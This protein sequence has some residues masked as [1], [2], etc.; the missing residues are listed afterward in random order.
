MSSGDLQ[1]HIEQNDYFGTLATVL[2]LL[3]QDLHR[4]GYHRHAEKLARLRDELQHLQR[5]YRIERRQVLTP[6]RR[7]PRSR[8]TFLASRHAELET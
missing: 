7:K 1:F 5:H 6:P 4:K 2:D 3:R 8:A